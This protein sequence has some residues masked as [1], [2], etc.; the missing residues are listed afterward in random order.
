MK[1]GESLYDEALFSAEKIKESLTKILGIAG[2]TIKSEKIG[3]V[4][5]DLY[6]VKG[7]HQIIIS[8]KEKI[9]DALEGCRDLAAMKCFA[10][11]KKDYVL[12]FPPISETEVLHFLFERTDWYF[13]MNEQTI[14]LWLVNPDRMETHPI[15]GYPYNEALKNHLT[16]PEA[17]DLI[18]QMAN[19][20]MNEQLLEEEDYF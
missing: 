18:A 8:I 2:Y 15:M 10:G 7:K 12:A 14:M 3:F 11:G 20:K 4:T 16:N 17:A 6:G 13:P 1:R 5:P 19:K 9:E